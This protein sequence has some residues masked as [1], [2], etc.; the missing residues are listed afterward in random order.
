M[1]KVE[2]IDI[3]ITWSCIFLFFKALDYR[4]YLTSYEIIDKIHKKNM[5]GF[6]C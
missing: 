3:I 2:R 4:P 5:F 1:N 6:T